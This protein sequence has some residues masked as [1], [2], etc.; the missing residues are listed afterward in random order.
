MLITT[1]EDAV[2]CVFTPARN[3]AQPQTMGLREY[4]CFCLRDE[5]TED[6]NHA[7]TEDLNQTPALSSLPLCRL[8]SEGVCQCRG[9]IR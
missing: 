5:E 3:T 6:L 2:Y 1:A 8:T 9:G 4:R 7:L